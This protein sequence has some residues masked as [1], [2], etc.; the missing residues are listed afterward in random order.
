MS[1]RYKILNTEAQSLLH[2]DAVK[3]HLRVSH[4]YDDEL[5]HRLIASAIA[6]AEK[7]LGIGLLKRKIGLKVLNNVV[8]LANRRIKLIYPPIINITKCVTCINGVEKELN[9]LPKNIDFVEGIVQIEPLTQ[10][11]SEIILEYDS[12]LSVQDTPIPIMQGILMHVG[13]MYDR[14]DPGDFMLPKHTINLYSAYR[15]WKI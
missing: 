11:D 3:N 2:I 12:G 10:C 1:I 15:K 9:I 8:H 14:D 6:S 13:D 4:N 7:F 5:I